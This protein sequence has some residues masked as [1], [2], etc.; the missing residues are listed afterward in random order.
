V[1]EGLRSLD[2][3]RRLAA[4]ET[5]PFVN[6]WTDL[7]KAISDV[8]TGGGSVKTVEAKQQEVNDAMAKLRT[9]RDLMEKMLHEGI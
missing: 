2:K 5:I 3:V 8:E 7:I 9:N 4:P 1:K 6:A